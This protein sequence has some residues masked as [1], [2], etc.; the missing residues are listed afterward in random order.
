MHYNRHW[1]N[2][3]WIKFP[4]KHLECRR[5]ETCNLCTYPQKMHQ[6]TITATPIARCL[7]EIRYY[8][9]PIILLILTPNSNVSRNLVLCSFRNSGN[10]NATIFKQH[11]TWIGTTNTA[12]TK[13]L[14]PVCKHFDQYLESL[15]II[16]NFN[17]QIIKYN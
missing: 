7:L 8:A 9:T 11:F 10:S 4:H 17:I 3:I 6:F 16:Y 14:K 2:F 13:A 5:K 12:N 1:L 15:W